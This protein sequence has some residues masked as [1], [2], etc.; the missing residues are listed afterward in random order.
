MKIAVTGGK[1]GTGK[2]TIA[3]SLAL[4]FSKLG[5]NTM[6]VDAD[7]DCPDDHLMLSMKRKKARDVHQPVPKFDS[8]KCTKCGKCASVCKQNC[9]VF[10]E[11]KP[12]AFVPD[13]C[14]GCKACIVVC[15]SG[16]VSE[17][18]KK[19]GEIYTGSSHG[20]ELV[21]GQL[22]IGQL[23]SGE[24]VSETRKFSESVESK[25]SIEL[26]IIDSAAGIGCPV[27]ASITGTNFVVAVT[28]PTPSALSDLDRVLKVVNHFNVPYGLVINKY[29]LSDKFGK[30]V[31]MFARKN[32]IPI[33]GKIPYDKKF[34]E[35]AIKMK[36][37]ISSSEEFEGMFSGMAEK[38]NNIIQ[39][40]K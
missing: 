7:V 39:K 15:P 6:L 32:D 18:R 16:A 23:A 21:S 12:P 13:M 1:G 22:G 8:R 31:E 5:K 34:I 4:V 37:V 3:T 28:E 26:S 14:I 19:I 30:K 9:I 11:G 20:I 29:D 10:V 25:K 2:S 17:G 38:I 40:K 27:I 35:S 36:P 24:M 33:I